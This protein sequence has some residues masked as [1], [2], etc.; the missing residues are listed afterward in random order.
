MGVD[1]ICDDHFL[2]VSSCMKGLH[3]DTWL[4]KRAIALYISG[5]GNLL[6]VSVSQSSSTS[7]LLARSTTPCLK[8]RANFGK[9]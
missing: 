6:M 7:S 2:I 8:K 5:V 9:L 1:G 4:V 3:V